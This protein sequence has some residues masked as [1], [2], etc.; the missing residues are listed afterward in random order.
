MNKANISK[1]IKVLKYLGY[2]IA[3]FVA[4]LLLYLL[5][6]AVL[7][8]IAVNT[9]EVSNGEETIWLLS[10]GAHTDI[11][12][13][14]HSEYINW[15]EKV[16]P[17]Y[18]K[19]GKAAQW[20]AFGWGDKGFYLN[21][22]TW[23]DLKFSTAVKAA[24][25]MSESAMHCTYESDP[26]YELTSVAIQI[27][28]TQ[29]KR[30]ISYIDGRFDKDAQGRYIPITTDAVYGN[31]D[32]FYEAKGTYNFTYTCNTWANYALRAAGQQ[33]ALWTATDMGIFRHYKE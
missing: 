20:L 24:F 8:R 6:A 1:I 17:T 16:L 9:E 15:E 27:S 19:G 25:W 31:E 30:L 18:T 14:T 29:Y 12:V 7:S 21:T 23:A 32:A 3:G 26:T 5:S 22:P 4:F 2:S 33:Y 13:P 11:V 10:N 28:S